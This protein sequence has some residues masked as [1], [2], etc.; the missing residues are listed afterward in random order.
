MTKRLLLCAVALIVAAMLVPAAQAQYATVQGVVKDMGGKPMVGATVHMVCKETGHKYDLKTNKKGEFISMGID[1]PRRYDITILDASGKT[2][3]SEQA[4]P[5]SS[6]D[7]T[8][9]YDLSKLAAQQ[10]GQMSEQ[11]RQAIVKEREEV[12]KENTKIKGLNELLAQAGAAQQAGNYDQAVSLMQQ[13]VQA[14][15]TRD[16]LWSRLADAERMAASKAADKDARTK[17]YQDAVEAY[18]KAIAIKQEKPASSTINVGDYYNNQ[19][20]A[21][22]KSGNV[23]GAINA[24]QQ[25]I[26]ANPA[27]AS[28]YYFN[29]GAVYT[30]TNQSDKAIEA[31]DKCIQADP[32]HA[33][34]FYFKGIALIGKSKTEGDK[35]IAPPGTAEAFNKYL[36]LAPTGPYAEPA[37]QMLAT[38]GAT[39]ET[40]FGK[41]PAKKK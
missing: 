17:L 31:F 3:Y 27:G 12:E 19:A 23:E 32:N 38:I 1:S 24:Y 25:A 15:A 13:A 40:N 7:V 29:L 2:I 11:E 28:T 34:A 35:M 37:K 16:I 6:G 39:V 9:D 14:D 21:Y 30:N 5:I 22:Y 41:K 4:H 26:A 10:A 33:D 36:E 20:D 18:N 8:L